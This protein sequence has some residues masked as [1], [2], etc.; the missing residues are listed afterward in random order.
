MHYPERTKRQQKK[1]E[2]PKQ[3]E[4]QT[5]KESFKGRGMMLLITEDEQQKKG[6]TECQSYKGP[7][8]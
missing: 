8:R 7:W 2:Q 4:P 3:A 5:I 1:M 6:I